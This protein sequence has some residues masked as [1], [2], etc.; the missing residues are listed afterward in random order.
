MATSG[1]VARFAG[2]VRTG[3]CEAGL[4]PVVELVL[5]AV[6]EPARFDPP[7]WPQPARDVRDVARR[8]TRT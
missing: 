5:A 3:A 7:E 2:A 4:V 8:R 6:A 1:P